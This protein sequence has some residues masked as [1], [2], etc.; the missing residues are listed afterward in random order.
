ML[1]SYIFG[2]PVANYM[3]MMRDD[4]PEKYERCFSQYIKEGIDPDDLEEIYR[5]VSII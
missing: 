2:E 4:D 1:K 5:K 3:R